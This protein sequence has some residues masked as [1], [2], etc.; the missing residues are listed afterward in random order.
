MLNLGAIQLCIDAESKDQP[1]RGGGST[2]IFQIDSVEE[3]ARELD[4]RKIGTSEVSL[5]AATIWKQ[6]T[7]R[8]TPWSSPK[9]FEQPSEMVNKRPPAQRANSVAQVLPKQC[10]IFLFCLPVAHFEQAIS[11]R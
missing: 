9:R 7:P 1:A 6:R 5:W 10:H 4:L 8:V 2:L 3:T 11:L